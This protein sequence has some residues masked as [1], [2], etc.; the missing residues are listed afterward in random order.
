MSIRAVAD[1]TAN[2]AA[3][4]TNVPRRNFIPR[5]RIAGFLFCLLAP[6]WLHAGTISGT[7]KDP[8]GAVIADARIEITGGD[9]LQPVVLASDG[10][11]KFTSE[12]L[13]PAK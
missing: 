2:L 9:L 7:V 11:G 10:L 5:V 8:S 6:T 12:D 1:L 3:N 4:P 13:K